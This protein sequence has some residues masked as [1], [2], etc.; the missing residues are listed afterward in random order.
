M[1]HADVTLSVC[2]RP[3]KSQRGITITVRGG[4]TAKNRC[5]AAVGSSHDNRRIVAK[6]CRCVTARGTMRSANSNGT[7]V[8]PQN[9]NLTCL[10]LSASQYSD[11]D[12]SKCVSV[13]VSG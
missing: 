11:L 1:N 5:R 12:A 9:G 7:F 13:G 2:P 8:T 4:C 3:L 6:Y 10:A